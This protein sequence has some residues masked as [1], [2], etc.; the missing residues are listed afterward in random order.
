MP[1]I[2]I[3]ELSS[4]GSGNGLSPVRRQAITSTNAEWLLTG[5]LG[6]N[7]S[8][9]WIKIHNFS[10]TKMHLKMLS[11]KWQPFCSRGDELSSSHLLCHFHIFPGHFL[12]MA[13]WLSV[14]LPGDL[15]W[16]RLWRQAYR[17]SSIP[18]L[19]D[20]KISTAQLPPALPQMSPNSEM[21]EV[22]VFLH[23]LQILLL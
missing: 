6:T 10:F 1:H 11:A 17:T 5:P 18:G 21:F 14:Q 2:C 16:K 22:F 19:V 8:E 15:S 7:F 3:N 9:I 12:L 23:T 20:C 4:I 13:P